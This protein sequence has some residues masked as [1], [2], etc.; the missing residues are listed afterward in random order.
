VVE[1]EMELF[2]YTKALTIDNSN[3]GKIGKVRQFQFVEELQKY[4]N[5]W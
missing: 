5:E 4:F 3:N 1:Y 2:A